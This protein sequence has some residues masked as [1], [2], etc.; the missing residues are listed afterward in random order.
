MSPSAKPAMAWGK[1]D[2]KCGASHALVAHYLDVAMALEAV[3]GAPHIRRGHAVSDLGASNQA[4]AREASVKD[5]RFD[6]REDAKAFARIARATWPEAFAPGGALPAEPAFMAQWAGLLSI[7]DW[8]GSDVS[9][10]PFHEVVTQDYAQLARRQTG[11]FACA[12]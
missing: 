10:F 6:G 9:H 4:D 11:P 5:N 2:R 1:Y 7:A 8:I 12:A 3:I